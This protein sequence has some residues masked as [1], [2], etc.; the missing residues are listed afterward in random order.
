MVQ[1]EQNRHT[2]NLNTIQDTVT[3]YEE[4]FENLN[5]ILQVVETRTSQP[6]PHSRVESIRTKRIHTPSF[7]SVVHSPHRA[8]SP[9]EE[10]R[11]RDTPKSAR[12]KQPEPYNKD[13][14]AETFLIRLELYFSDN[15]RYF[16]DEDKKSIRL[17]S[18]MGPK[19]DSW[20]KPLLRKWAQD[21]RNTPLTSWADLKRSFII[22]FGSPIEA[23]KA[24]DNI[25]K[26]TQTGSAQQYATKFKEY[27][28]DL[29]WNDET[30]LKGMF[31]KN[32]KP[33][34]KLEV[35]KATIDP[36]TQ[37]WRLEEWIEYAISQDN[38]IHAAKVETKDQNKT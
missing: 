23:T 19:A 36:H 14:D 27:A 7:H 37:G 21:D 24:L 31:I 38:I 25:H 9:V 13:A 26:L 35:Q 11:E 10:L 6:R 12:L 1:E 16:Q 20:S 15:A 22:Y 17:L 30:P 4:R 32:L 33:E 29:D 8:H 34:V 2:Q 5:D 28:Q 3:G 18:L